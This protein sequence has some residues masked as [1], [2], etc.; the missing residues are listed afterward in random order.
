MEKQPV[1]RPEGARR[2]DF[3]GL[4][5]W[6]L[7]QLKDYKDRLSQADYENVSFEVNRREENHLIEDD[8]GPGFAWDLISHGFLFK[9]GEILYPTKAMKEYLAKKD[10]MKHSRLKMPEKDKRRETL[11]ERAE[12]ALEATRDVDNAKFA[13]SETR[14]LKIEKAL[15]LDDDIRKG[16]EDLVT[17]LDKKYSANKGK[18]LFV[19]ASEPLMVNYFNFGFLRNKKLGAVWASKYDDYVNSTDII[20]E[21]N[22]DSTERVKGHIVPKQNIF[23]IDITTAITTDDK[24]GVKDKFNDSGYHRTGDL[25]WTKNLAC[26]WFP[27]DPRKSREEKAVPHFIVGLSSD[28]F[29]GIAN[30]LRYDKKD[31]FV[32]SERDNDIDFMIAS[33]LYEQAKMQRVFLPPTADSEYVEKIENLI[34]IFQNKVVDSLGLDSFDAKEYIRKI[35]EMS[36]RDKVYKITIEETRKNKNN[37]IDLHG[38]N[39]SKVF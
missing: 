7:L 27:D 29:R 37:F 31:G 21:I 12:K 16:Y 34:L 9:K 28:T 33:E 18:D 11:A 1:K 8:E 30:A 6:T 26:C 32:R 10:K 35:T 5:Y 15:H 36:G 2:G 13:I 22:L 3:E 38:E 20:A 17:K 4:N 14:R 23:S 24:T 19:D 25:Q 39:Y